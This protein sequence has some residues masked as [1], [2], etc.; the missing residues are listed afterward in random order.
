MAG[1]LLLLSTS[2][3]TIT[4]TFPA[5]AATKSMRLRTRFSNLILLPRLGVV[6]VRR[7]LI[8][9]VKQGPL[10]EH[11]S[12]EQAFASRESPYRHY[13]ITTAGLV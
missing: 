7:R 6:C 12:R 4:S 8:G 1:L 11:F 9:R 3:S 5:A 10:K 13:V 2:T